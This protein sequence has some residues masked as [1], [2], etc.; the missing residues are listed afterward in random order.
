ME[1]VCDMTPSEIRRELKR[2]AEWLGTGSI[3]NELHSRARIA[4]V[5]RRG[6]KLIRTAPPKDKP[7]ETE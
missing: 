4:A 5:L 7:N 2:Y 1:R 6:A 3:G